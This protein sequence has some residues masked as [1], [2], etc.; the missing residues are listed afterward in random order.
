MPR[1]DVGYSEQGSN[2]GLRA[3]RDH[4]GQRADSLAWKQPTV[5][6]LME[7]SEKKTGILIWDLDVIGKKKNKK[8]MEKQT[9]NLSE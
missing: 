4:K 3:K 5:Y 6:W 1:Q 8:K 2:A 9:R 7:K